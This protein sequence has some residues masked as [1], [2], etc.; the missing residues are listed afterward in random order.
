MYILSV[1]VVAKWL[2][3]FVNIELLLLL[4]FTGKELYIQTSTKNR[5]KLVRDIS[6]RK[7][8][9]NLGALALTKAAQPRVHRKG[10]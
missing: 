3:I 10:H 6:I 9:Q 7:L 8:T 1:T 5:K 4:F 2:P